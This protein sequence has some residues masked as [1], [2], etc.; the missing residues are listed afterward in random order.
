[1]K[2][3]VL[4]RLCAQSHAAWRVW[5]EAGSPREGLLFEQKNKL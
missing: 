1:M 5:K 3:D 2:D 4:S